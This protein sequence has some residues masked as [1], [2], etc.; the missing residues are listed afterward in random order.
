MSMNAKRPILAKTEPHVWTSL[1]ITAV[2]VNPD[3]QGK[4]VPLVRKTKHY[5]LVSRK[6][7]G[8]HSLSFSNQ[9][10]ARCQ[11]SLLKNIPQQKCALW[12]IT[13]IW[14]SRSLKTIHLK[15]LIKKL[16]GISKALKLEA[17]FLSAKGTFYLNLFGPNLSNR[18]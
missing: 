17:N 10:W 12:K 15:K 1:E 3:S 14:K 7:R 9:L 2:R 16:P 4:L 8:G 6:I 5:L 13:K 18:E 11:T